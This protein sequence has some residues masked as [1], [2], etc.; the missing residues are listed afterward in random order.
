MSGRYAV[1]A[2][3]ATT[4]LVLVA[5]CTTPPGKDP[6]QVE[7]TPATSGETG[8]A[9]SDLV[10]AVSTRLGHFPAFPEEHLPDSVAASLQAV[11]D[12]AV[13]DDI[14][15][16]AT[17]AV[18]VAGSGS[19]AGAAGVDRHGDALDPE[20]PLLTA[21]VGKT[22]TAAQIL[23]LVDDGRLRLDDRAADHFPPELSAFDANDATIRDLLGMRSGLLDPR[24]FFAL[25]ERHAALAELADRVPDPQAP[26][27]ST[28][29]YA[30]TNFVLLGAIVEQATGRSL[31]RTTRAGVL[32]HPDLGGMTYSAAKG[33]L[34]GDGWDMVATPASL[35]RWGYE[36]YGGSVVS[37]A[38]LREMTDFGGEWYGLGTIDFT[39][40]DA[41]TFDTP[42]VGHGGSEESHFVRLVAFLR[43]GL[44]VSVQ[45]NADDFWEVE[46]VVEQMRE[47]VQ[48]S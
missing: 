45:A 32:D 10:P 15:R 17:A 40:P 18:V 4:L 13:A 5:G 8:A 25:V 24:S 44:V 37:V 21:S 29:S 38:S 48:P 31:S 12:R 33:A 46:H 9:A 19:W 30:N 39:H 34:A 2:G 22:V 3:C 11:L 47:V 43:T 23:R 35:A 27:G 41:G 16:G 14:V 28:I 7:A 6:E 1:R 42:V 20:S 26:A 36:L